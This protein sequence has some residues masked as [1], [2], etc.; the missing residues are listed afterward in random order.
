MRLRQIDIKHNCVDAGFALPATMIDLV[1]VSWPG[2]K[3]C[4]TATLT[5]VASKE[6]HVITLKKG[7]VVDDNSR[8][9]PKTNSLLSHRWFSDNNRKPMASGE[10]GESKAR[11]RLSYSKSMSSLGQKSGSEAS[12]KSQ[13]FLAL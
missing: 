8:P 1:K 9:K 12:R 5:K 3:D 7:R 13:D 11:F 4:K 10:R 2:R 6:V